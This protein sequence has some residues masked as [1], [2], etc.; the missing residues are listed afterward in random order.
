L[1]TSS[2]EETQMADLIFIAATV[3]FFAVAWLYALGCDRL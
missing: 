1:L 2:C 3:G